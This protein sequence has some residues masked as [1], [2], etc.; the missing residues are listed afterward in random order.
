MGKGYF[1]QIN[2]LASVPSR[3][4]QG[5]R[6]PTRTYFRQLTHG[7]PR[8]TC[9]Y[10][11]CTS[12]VY[13]RRPFTCDGVQSSLGLGETLT[14]TESIVSSRR[15]FVTTVTGD[16]TAKTVLAY[17]L[18]FSQINPYCTTEGQSV[19]VRPS[20]IGPEGWSTKPI[21]GYPLGCKTS[22]L[23]WLYFQDLISSS[24]GKYACPVV[25][26][27]RGTAAAITISGISFNQNIGT[28]SPDNLYAN[29]VVFGTTF[30]A[31]ETDTRTIRVRSAT[32]YYDHFGRMDIGATSNKDFISYDAL[33]PPGTQYHAYRLTF[34]GGSWRPTGSVGDVFVMN[35]A[36]GALPCNYSQ[37][38]GSNFIAMDLYTDREIPQWIVNVGGTQYAYAPEPDGSY[39]QG[40]VGSITG[41]TYAHTVGSW[42]CKTLHTFLPYYG[43]EVNSPPRTWPFTMPTS[44]TIERILYP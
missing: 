16:G 11:E 2:A 41:N 40:V 6:R 37:G 34:T 23:Q 13:W 19:T 24:Y 43:V 1:E 5:T 12:N 9:I 7:A 17:P 33:A 36:A 38:S 18:R 35:T 28:S 14:W 8:I 29:D 25:N 31:G 39:I 22:A 44:F 3:E 32:N 42:D 15:Q 4:S 30:A 10:G 26:G 20:L 21:K 27:S